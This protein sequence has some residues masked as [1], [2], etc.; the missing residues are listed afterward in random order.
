MMQIQTVVALLIVAG[1]VFFLVRRF[2]NSLRKG[3]TPACNCSCSGCEVPDACE[4]NATDS[5][6]NLKGP[7]PP[8]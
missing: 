3:G 8:K 6:E 1:A 5:A 2:R 7:Y 4:E